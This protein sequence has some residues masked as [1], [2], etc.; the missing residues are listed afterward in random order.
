MT[1]KF[2]SIWRAQR[3]LPLWIG[4]LCVSAFAQDAPRQIQFGTVRLEDG[5]RIVPVQVDRLEGVLAIDLNIVLDSKEVQ[6][7]DVRTTDLLDGFFAIHNVVVDT[8]KFAAASAQAAAAPTTHPPRARPRHSHAP[9][10]EPPPDAMAR[11]NV[12]RAG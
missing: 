8:L 6:I 9:H 12:F 3:L 2:A 5:T 7:L 1:I 10:P 11:P 4:L